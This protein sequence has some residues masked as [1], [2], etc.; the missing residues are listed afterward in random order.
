M[1]TAPARQSQISQSSG[2][3][4][5]L[6]RKSVQETVGRVCVYVLLILGAAFV[7]M[8]FIWMISTALKTPG[9]EFAFPIQW[10]PNPVVWRNFRDGLTVL[11]FKRWFA[12]TGL[13][14]G[15]VI[16]GYTISC[17]LA[18]FGFARLDFPGRDGLFLLLL[19][20]MMMPY[21]VTMTPTFILFKYIG[22]LDSFKALV[23]P[24]FFA[25]GGAFYIF[26]LRQFFL[27]LPRELDD[28]ARIDGCSTF[29]IFWR[30]ALPLVRP[31]LG[32]VI[33]FAFM[34]S[35]NDFLGPLIFLSSTDNFTVS[36]GLRY[37]QGQFDV[38][39]T[40]LMAVSLVALS[41][42]IALFLIAQRYYIQGIVISGVKG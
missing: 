1:N 25:G 27:T 33:V 24:S 37:F 30:I 41:P 8:P 13:I 34:A 15:T 11:P 4:A 42:C 32:M 38:Q 12:N 39:W 22:W 36:L 28:A 19:S 17:S 14:T 29:G 35:W 18:A 7:L 20:T 23:V 3:A 5:W 31:A 10:I 2:P 9:R 16:V 6:K 26:L 21:P 40:W